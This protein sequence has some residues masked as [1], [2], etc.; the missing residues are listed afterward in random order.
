MLYEQYS[1][2]VAT[3]EHPTAIRSGPIG[4]KG[5][6]PFALPGVKKRRLFEDKPARS[7]C[8]LDRQGKWAAD[9]PWP[10]R[11]AVG[12][13]TMPV[14]FFYT[15]ENSLDSDTPWEYEFHQSS[16]RLCSS[17]LI[18]KT[19]MGECRKTFSAWEPNRVLARLLRPL[20]P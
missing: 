11:M 15:M 19:G 6:Q 5:D 2:K 18:L 14:S 1:L 12:G 16:C 20:C 7:S 17:F 10:D 13:G 4:P 3:A 8:V 9:G